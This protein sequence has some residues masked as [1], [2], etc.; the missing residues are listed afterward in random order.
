MVQQGWL[1]SLIVFVEPKR[2][3]MNEKRHILHRTL[4]VE[5]THEQLESVAGGLT[6]SSGGMNAMQTGRYYLSY[7]DFYDRVID[8]DYGRDND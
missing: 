1:P 3:S 4:S 7:N 8:A 6:A 5:L 2:E